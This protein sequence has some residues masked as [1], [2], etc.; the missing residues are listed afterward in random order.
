M[1]R[2]L[3]ALS[4]IGFASLSILAQAP[5]GWRMRVDRSRN[6]EDPDNRPDLKVLATAKGMHITTGPAGTFWNPSNA[7]TG[8]YTLKATFTLVKPS[9]HV[10]YYGLIFGGAD[11]DG[12]GQA[13]TY[14]V[15]GQDG[16]YVIRH[17]EGEAVR[18]VAR[19]PHSAVKRPDSSGSSTNALEVRVSGNTISYLVNGMVVQT[20]PKADL[21]AKT[22]GL[23]GV[24]VNHVLDVQVEGFALQKGR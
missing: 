1:K 17:R 11:L 9:S 8:D 16:T 24:R 14:F 2:F 6:A 5:A 20:T 7:A 13:Y 18:E 19:M 22:D 3:L 12:P 10:N 4:I 15:I 23:V 21:T